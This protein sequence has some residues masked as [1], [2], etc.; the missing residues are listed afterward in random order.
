MQRVRKH[1]A[2]KRVNRLLVQFLKAGVLSEEQF[3]RTDAGTPQGGIISPL[4]ANIALGLIEERYERWVEHKTKLQARRTCD[5]ITAANRARSTDRRAGRVV[6]FPVRYA[7]DF[8]VLVRGTRQQAETERDAL[9]KAL[10][11]DMGLTLSPDKTRITD[12]ADGFQ[13]LGH[14]VSMRWDDRFGWSPRIE[15]PKSKAADL[16]RKVKQ[17]TTRQTLHWSLDELL[18]KLNPILRGWAHYYH[19]CTGAKDVLCGLDWYARDRVWRWMRKKYPKAS[20]RWLLQHRRASRHRP[21]RRVWQGERHEQYQMGWL[22]V[23]RYRR[24]W[25]T[26]PDFTMIPG[27][28]DA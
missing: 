26:P 18:Q 12:P 6:M 3:L 4:L 23:Q 13:F 21:T 25:M 11:D 2:D 14:R 20:V 28:P 22:K 15:V 24:G 10:R 9:A 5:G 16:R 17:L 7:D 1:C 27:E 8:V 19:Y